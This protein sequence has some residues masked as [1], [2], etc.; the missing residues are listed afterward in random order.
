MKARLTV[1]FLLVLAVSVASW[2][3]GEFPP[4]PRLRG[5]FNFW[6]SASRTCD[7]A[8][9]SARTKLKEAELEEDISQAADAVL[10]ATVA[11][12]YE[13]EKKLAVRA[14]SYY[15]ARRG[16][17]VLKRYEEYGK[18]I[19]RTDLVK[20]QNYIGLYID[21]GRMLS[22]AD[23]EKLEKTLLERARFITNA[24]ELDSEIPPDPTSE[25]IEH[26]AAMT[27]HLFAIAKAG[28]DIAQARASYEKASQAMFSYVRDFYYATPGSVDAFFSRTRR[29]VSGCSSKR[30]QFHPTSQP[31]KRAR[32]RRSSSSSR[33]TKKR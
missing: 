26:A 16:T 4:G 3:E 15:A 21:I 13:T 8:W 23:L 33:P 2:G 12:R 19:N 5:D 14:S 17:E 30:Y 32:R 25:Y 9:A 1:T 28:A 18:E 7:L 22:L 11:A 31:R 20:M 27:E 29:D 10:K 6:T 24:L